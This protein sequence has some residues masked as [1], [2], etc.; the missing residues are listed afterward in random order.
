[1]SA[2]FLLDVR[3]RYREDTS[4]YPERNVYQMQKVFH[5]DGWSFDQVAER[6]AHRES[7]SNQ[8]IGERTRAAVAMIL[9]KGENGIEILFIQRAAH[10]LDPWSGHIA[11]PG[12]KLEAGEHECQAACRETYEEIGVDLEHAYYL[13]RLS[14]IVGANLPVLVSC[15]VFGIDRLHCCPTLNDEVC[16]LFWVALTDLA[17]QKRHLHCTV[18]FDDKRFDVPAIQ[19]PIENKPVLWGITYRLV[20]QFLD[21]LAGNSILDKE[22]YRLPEVLIIDEEANQ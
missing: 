13:G 6:L 3:L 10:D 4:Q 17:D 14:D 1:M 9:S 2:H 22:C 20:L 8:T 15:C 12:G 7:G 21:L 19:L 5:R 16:D 18:A 11:F